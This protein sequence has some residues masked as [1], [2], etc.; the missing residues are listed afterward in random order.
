MS[1]RYQRQGQPAKRTRRII[2]KAGRP[3]RPVSAQPATGKPPRK[4]L[5]TRGLDVIK[6]T[7]FKGEPLQIRRR[8]P[9]RLKGEVQ[10]GETKTR[11]RPSPAIRP[12]K[13]RPKNGGTAQRIR[14]R[15]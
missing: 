9:T 6:G 10:Q 7:Q 2:D 3:K 8:V 11:R 14:E 4:P 12:A 5:G 1:M 15:Q 13:G